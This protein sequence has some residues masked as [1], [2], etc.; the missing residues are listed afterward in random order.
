MDVYIQAL[1]LQLCKQKNPKWSREKLLQKYWYVDEEGRH[2][3]ALMN[4]KEFRLK[5]LADTLLIDYS[6]VRT[7]ANAYID[8]EYF[9]QR[10][11]ER[12]ILNVTGVFRSIWERQN[13]RCYHCAKKILRDEKK[14]LIETFPDQC[15]FAARMSYIHERCI[16]SP[17]EFVDV[18]TIPTSLDEVLKLLQRLDDRQAFLQ[19]EFFA[20]F[21]FF[22]KCTQKSIALKFSQIEKII[23]KKLGENALI[24]EF[25][26]RQG[27]SDISQCWINNGY[28]IRAINLKKPRR[29][30][31]F[32]RPLKNTDIVNIPEII[33]S[34]KIPKKAKYELE[35]Y[36]T[37]ILKKYAV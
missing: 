20:L 18:D 27:L 22:Q 29:R 35:N 37:Y 25:W 33:R 8:L 36:F 9:E 16:Y 2:C 1:L 19:D 21:E 23:G 14:V 24:A 17:F 3:Y 12:E 4:K 5:F 26:T 6:P 10:S 31:T 15:R 7:N 34:G 28:E 30:I 13:G 11:N 32:Q